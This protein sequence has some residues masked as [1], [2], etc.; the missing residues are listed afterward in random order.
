MNILHLCSYYNTSIL[1]RNMF[2]ALEELDINQMVYIPLR[3]YGDFVPK[4][5]GTVRKKYEDSKLIKYEYCNCINR[6]NNYIYFMKVNIMYN[7]LI[8]KIKVNK[9]DLIHAHSLYTNGGVAYKL[10]KETGKKYIVAVRATDIFILEKMPHL[11]YKM[12]KIIKNA[13]KV[14]FISYSLKNK[15]KKLIDINFYKFIESK[16]EVIPNGVDNFWL[17]NKYSSKEVFNKNS[18][19]NLIY[20]G[21]F[22]KRKN[23]ETLVKVVDYL[24][25]NKIYSNIT[26]IGGG[27]RKEN[28]ENLINSS[29]YKN[30]FKIYSW[31][32]N[33]SE[34]MNK[35]RENDIFIMLSEGETF[36]ISYLEALSQGLPILYTKNDGIDG[37]FNK[38]VGKALKIGQDL[39]YY[40][41]NILD[42]NDNLKLYYKNSL[43]EVDKFS[44]DNIAKLYKEIYTKIIR[45]N[46]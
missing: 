41:Q 18:E 42:I 40:S 24:N 14:I 7:N 1:Y 8:K 5:Y 13:E 23:V 4:D 43:E 38:K 26:L 27:D 37:F 46:K 15:F 36:G 9:Y 32:N 12:K 19:I 21:T 31:C 6:V 28:I 35:Y 17:D 44:W 16:I 3:N 2:L 20:V 11:L 39:S 30:R 34:L 22:I 29:K 45:S 10:F 33:K 25:Y